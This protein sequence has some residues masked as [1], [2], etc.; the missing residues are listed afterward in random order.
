M[1][2]QPA[3]ALKHFMPESFACNAYAETHPARREPAPAADSKNLMTFLD[4]VA[5]N[6]VPAQRLDG[7]IASVEA[8]HHELKPLPHSRSAAFLLSEISGDLLKM[9]DCGFN[10]R[11]LRSQ[12][13]A[14]QP[15][16]KGLAT[17]F[18]LVQVQGE[19]GAAI[20]LFW[21]RSPEGWRVSSYAVIA[22]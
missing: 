16:G 1:R 20:T 10:P 12:Q 22:D 2:K 14:R 4:E 7:V 17:S 9:S 19:E 6:A 8:E 15:A 11:T 13:P 21:K 5:K 18:R 3:E